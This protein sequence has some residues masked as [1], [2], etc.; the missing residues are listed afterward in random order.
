MGE[1]T[2]KGS[3]PFPIYQFA[4]GEEVDFT[5]KPYTKIEY[6]YDDFPIP[7]NNKYTLWEGGGG[8]LKI[9]GYN[10]NNN[11]W[12]L[13]RSTITGS[14][15]AYTDTVI[16]RYNFL[17]GASAFI[18]A[19][20][21]PDGTFRVQVYPRWEADGYD[22][23]L[24]QINSDPRFN[25]NALYI[26]TWD[27]ESSI[28]E[29]VEDWDESPTAD[30]NDPERTGPQG[31]EFADTN[32][33]GWGNDDIDLPNNIDELSYSGFITAYRLDAGNVSALGE[34]IFTTNTWTILQ[35]KFNGVGN[36]IDYIISAVE[37]PYKAASNTSQDFNLGGIKVVDNNNNYVPLSVL[38]NRYHKINF[39]SLQVK[40]TWGTEKDY[41]TTDIAIYLPYVGVK[42]LDTSIVMN[43]TIT[44]KGV[45]DVWNGDIMYAIIVDNKAAAYKYLGSRGIVYRFQGNCGKTVPIGR[46]DSTTQLL[47]MAGS[48]ASMGVGLATGMPTG[49][50]GYTVGNEFGASGDVSGGVNPRLVGG[51]AA[52]MIGAMTM[53]PKI[54]MSGGVQGSIGRGDVQYPYLI[55]KQSVP[56]YPKGWRAHFGA[57]R[58]QTLRLGDL[59]GYVKC[60]DVHA[61]NIEG[62]NDA[63]RAAIEQALKAGVY[64]S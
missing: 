35:N 21:L 8:F 39:G 45:L 46:V 25:G 57:P 29:Y 61:E 2:V 55:I 26:G 40:E 28:V 48:I 63:E 56:V 6:P 10:S 24:S 42:D 9:F 38:D 44:V 64:V 20:T 33:L 27:P 4:E 1:Y 15:P 41:S 18:W 17:R 47:A 7:A 23:A 36:P 54:S 12:N 14:N 49:A 50:M 30:E 59:S 34:A 53:G 37:I 19:F 13:E 31:G 58:Y 3:V 16:S 52:G 22:G 11:P 43:S 5:G 62:A 60:A 32:P 51:G